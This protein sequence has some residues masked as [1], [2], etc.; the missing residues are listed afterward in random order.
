MLEKLINLTKEL[1]LQEQVYFTGFVKDENLKFYYHASDLFVLASNSDYH[2][3]KI[4]G[5]GIVFL[6]AQAAGLAVIGTRCGG[7]P[8]AV[9]EGEGGWLIDEKDTL[10][11]TSHLKKLL[12]EPKTIQDQG[13]LGLERIKR[14]F[15]FDNYIRR[16]IELI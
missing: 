16:L 7:I 9:R 2:N 4:E 3:N 10:A 6:E 11:L 5:F 13:F 1:N 14:E 15:S 12:T 8:D